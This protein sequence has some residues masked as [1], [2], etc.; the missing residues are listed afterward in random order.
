MLVIDTNQV[1]G[2]IYKDGNDFSV[3]LPKLSV[4]ENKEVNVLLKKFANSGCS[5][6]GTKQDTGDEATDSLK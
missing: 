3:Q 4:A 5:T 2:A 6:G 1:V